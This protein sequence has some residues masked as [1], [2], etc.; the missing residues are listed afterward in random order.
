MWQ[1]SKQFPNSFEF[2]EH[3][4]IT[5]LDHLY[6]CRFGTFLC[7]TERERVAE[8]KLNGSPFSLRYSLI[9][10]F[11]QYIFHRPQA[12]DR[13]A[14]VVH[15]RRTGTVSQSTVRWPQS[16]HTDGLETGGQHATHSLVEGS[17]LSLESVDATARSDLSANA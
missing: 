14:V 12:Q 16:G 1:V 7:N 10:T 11:C 15:E 3:F 4:L 5:I 8:G 9:L 13:F 6:S 2:N 17:V